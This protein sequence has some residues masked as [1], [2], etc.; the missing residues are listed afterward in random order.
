MSSGGSFWLPE[1]ASTVAGQVDAGWDL[2]LW[3]SAFFFV[4]VVGGM[5]F[6]AIRY[7]RRTEEELPN[8]PDHNTR[9]EIVWTAIPVAIVLVLFVVGFKGFL[10]Q[11]IA[12]ANALE[13]S[14]TAEKWMWTFAYPN[15]AISVNE[16]KV[17]LGRPVKLVMSSKD[18]IHSFYVPEFRLKK[19]VVP[20]SY[21][22]AWFEAT[23]LGLK[24]ITCTEF[25][26]TGHSAMRGKLEV[27]AEKDFNEWLESGAEEKDVPPVLAGEKLSTKLACT[28]CHTTDGKPGTGPTWKGLAE[29]DVQL[30][31]GSTV[32]A[33]E[34]YLRES[35]TDPNAKVVK[36]FQ[37][38]MPVFKGLV[39]QKQ[40]DA[41][42]A[43]IKSLK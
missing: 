1:Q 3:V 15:G 32:K 18:V 12:P 6:F 37:P 17:P 42:V 29:H 20:S 8:A 41:L 43:Y 13:V 19:D 28:T 26:G 4:L 33:D 11:Q 39:S 27:M 14:V 2:V 22:T 21:T 40:L 34:Q 25:C 24:T 5:S 23:E 9:I 36:G 30:A 31:D 38:V 7:R 10:N 16:L 35:I